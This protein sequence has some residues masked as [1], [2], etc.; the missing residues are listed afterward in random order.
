MS[1]ATERRLT[2]LE[3]DVNEIRNEMTDIRKG[4]TDM[5]KDVGKILGILEG[6]RQEQNDKKSEK[7]NRLT[8]INILIA[9]GAGIF[10]GLGVKLIEWIF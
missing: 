3:N 10:G 8:L 1:K 4:Q 9:G 5:A 2:N 7:T 6:R